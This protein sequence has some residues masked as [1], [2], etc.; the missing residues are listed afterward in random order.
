[1]EEK[2]V[3][4]GK[5]H[6]EELHILPLTPGTAIGGIRSRHSREEIA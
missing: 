4:C 2:L 3:V 1:M 5:L 6:G